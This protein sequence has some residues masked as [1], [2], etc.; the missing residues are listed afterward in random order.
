M[1]NPEVQD[2]WK[3]P[4]VTKRLLNFIFDEGQCISQWGSFRNEYLHLGLLRYLI[5]EAV[6]FYIPSATLPPAV[7]SDIGEILHLR[8]DSTER[9]M[10]SNDRPEIALVVRGLA[11][12]A[13][14]FRDLAFIIPAGFQEGDPPPEKFLIFFN[15]KKEAEDASL[16]L[17]SRLPKVLRGKIKWFHAVNTPEYREEEVELLKNNETWGYCC[18][19]SFGMVSNIFFLRIILT[20]LRVWTSPTSNS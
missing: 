13:N 11:F 16:Y 18:T 14:S 9:I 20:Y 6:P 4:K 12:P 5:P 7:I 8:A 2:L 19:D 1:A 17:Q 3:K 15:S 10:C